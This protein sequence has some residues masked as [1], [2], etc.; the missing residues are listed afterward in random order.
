M[1]EL[2]E[3]FKD[4]YNELSPLN[5]GLVLNYF[6]EV[7]KWDFTPNLAKYAVEY[8]KIHKNCLIHDVYL[9]ELNDTENKNFKLIPKEFKSKYDIYKKSYINCIKYKN[10]ESFIYDDIIKLIGTEEWS[11]HIQ[12][13]NI[14][15]ACPD[16]T[17]IEEFFLRKSKNSE[18]KKLQMYFYANELLRTQEPDE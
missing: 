1:K 16:Y 18:K 14:N 4:I 7:R 17:Y 10:K 12:P 13:F 15:C 9:K 8:K 5:K 11:T 2:Y 6:F 3:A